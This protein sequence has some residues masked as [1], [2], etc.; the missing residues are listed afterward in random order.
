MATTAS[1]FTSLYAVSGMTCDHCV[2][3][4]TTEISNVAGVTHVEVELTTGQVTVTTSTTVDD[5]AV[6]A[7]VEKAGYEVTASPEPPA[8]SCCGTCH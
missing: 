4:I 7:A 1:T 2:Q 5:T 8:A 6:I 3:S